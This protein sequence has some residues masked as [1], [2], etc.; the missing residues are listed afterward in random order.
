MNVDRPIVV[1]ISGFSSNVGKTTLMCELLRSLPGW[2]A[3][4]LTRGHYRSCGRDPAGC[5][6][7]D[8]LRDEPVI[9]SGREA[10]YQAGKDTGL[11]WEAG[12][13][14][15]HWVIVKDD[16]VE[17]GIKAALARVKSDGVLIE[18]NSFL[19][20]VTPEL[21]VMCALSDG[22]KIKPSARAG[23]KQSDVL[24]LSSLNVDGCSA[25]KQ[26]NDW[27]ANL[28]IAVDFNGLPIFTREDIPRLLSLIHQPGELAKL[29]YG[30]NR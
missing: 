5:C 10:N 30:H 7:S 14:N 28:P 4:K 26:F 9:R 15:V 18:G 12:A 1:A 21:A 13:S 8:L 19:N 16:Q 17:Q 3:I 25:R 22:G 11:F 29:T 24:F 6:V 2:E 27:R 23:L 20:Y